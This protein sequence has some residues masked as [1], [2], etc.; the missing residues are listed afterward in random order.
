MGI[1]GSATYELVFEDCKIP[2]EN[3]IVEPGTGF[4]KILATL[5]GGR[6]GV[7]VQALGIAQGS[8]D[9]C[10]E[11]VTEVTVSWSTNTLDEEFKNDMDKAV[12]IERRLAAMKQVSVRSALSFMCSPASRILRR[13]LNG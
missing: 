2:K 10:K 1:R 8:I 13:F 9:R 6:I 3:L 12:S 11:Y 7:A 4:K 5:D